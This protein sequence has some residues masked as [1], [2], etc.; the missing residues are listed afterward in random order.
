MT[1]LSVNMNVDT[2]EKTWLTPPEIIHA[3]GPFDIDPYC[4]PEMP[5]RTAARMIC[6]PADGLAVDWNGQRVW[7][8]P[9]YGREAVPFVR[10]LAENRGGGGILLIFARTDTALWHDFIFPR[11]H[12][13]LF[14]RGRLRFYHADGTPGNTA[15]AP[16]AL[17]AFSALDALC[18]R[19]ANATHRLFAG[20]VV[21]LKRT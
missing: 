19:G 2:G 4:P 1:A 13:V 16:S 17:V 15:T 6:R 3:L 14:M 12:S 20:H 8:N 10:K 9:P 18:L 11:A 5:W 21:E 7:L